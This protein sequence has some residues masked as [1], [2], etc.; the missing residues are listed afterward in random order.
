MKPRLIVIAGPNGSGKTSIT[1]QLKEIKHKWMLG[2]TY[3]NP[4]DIARAQFGDWNNPA[5]VL[6]AAEEATRQR[7]D[8]LKQKADF[9][10]ETVLS[11]TEKIDF[12]KQAQAAGYFI[13][14]FFVGT[15]SP[16]IN[17]A[18]IT[19]R[20]QAGGHT[21][22]IEKIISRYEKSMLNIARV[23]TFADR[24]YFYDNS[25]D[26]ASETT[27]Q[28]VPLFRTKSGVVID[29]YPD[30]TDHL[31]ASFIYNTLRKCH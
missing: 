11:S 13:R 28:W 3:I 19:T 9:A 14:V 17:A 1:D 21:V 10:V 4:D 15:D 20:V 5:S 27:R 24:V 29:T 6:K 31:W 18:R 30:P 22:P 2:C 25:T 23:A 7:Y 16:Q 12:L 8:L 26:F